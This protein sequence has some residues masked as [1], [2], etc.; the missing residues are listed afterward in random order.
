MPVISRL[1]RA[2]TLAL[3]AS[4]VLGA[5]SAHAAAYMKLGDIKGQMS[6]SDDKKNF[7]KGW[8]E[9]NSVSC[10]AA[11]STPSL[12]EIAVTKVTDSTS[13]ALSQAAASGRRFP[14]AKIHLLDAS[15]GAA[16]LQYELKNVMISSYQTG[17]N[18]AADGSI[19][20]ETLSL[21]F[22][23]ITWRNQDGS[24]GAG[25]PN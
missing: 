18:P 19:P 17:G 6:T 11:R 8:I 3:A 9:L 13:P 21:N 4:V 7:Y 10:N 24:K 22:D 2:S 20:T 12:S 1:A 15:G 5:L 25:C 16:Y 14:S 23:K